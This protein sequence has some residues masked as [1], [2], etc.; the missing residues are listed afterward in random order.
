[1]FVQD[2][3]KQIL[4]YTFIKLINNNN[5][6]SVNQSKKSAVCEN[7]PLICNV[8]QA[9]DDYME[10]EKKMMEGSIQND[11]DELDIEET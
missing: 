4:Y 3:L 9:A 5:A 1:M 8:K 7:Q 10:S 6:L 2:K 11:G